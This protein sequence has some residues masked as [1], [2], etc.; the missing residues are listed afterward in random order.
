MKVIIVQRTDWPM[1][2]VAVCGPFKEDVAE[3]FLHTY[4]VRENEEASIYDL[5]EVVKEGNRFLYV[6]LEQES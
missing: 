2:V 1:G 3:N 5:V 6:P 4:P